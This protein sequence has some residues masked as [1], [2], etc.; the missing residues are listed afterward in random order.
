MKTLVNCCLDHFKHLCL[1][2][3][4]HKYGKVL[5]FDY[6]AFMLLAIMLSVMRWCK[7]R[8]LAVSCI[9]LCWRFSAV[10]AFW[11]ISVAH[12]GPR[13]CSTWIL[14]RWSTYLNRYWIRLIYYILCRNQAITFPFII[15]V[16]V[17]ECRINII[18]IAPLTCSIQKEAF[19]SQSWSR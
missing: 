10:L 2:K 12:C 3:C 1:C 5:W 9:T 4:F 11:D 8:V 14:R 19:L 16:W 7:V 17:D 15:L 13:F 6:F 18:I